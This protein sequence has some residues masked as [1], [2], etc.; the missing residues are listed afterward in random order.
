MKCLLGSIKAGNHLPE[1]MLKFYPQLENLYFVKRGFFTSFNPCNYEPT[2]FFYLD[3]T[4]EQIF[5]WL[6]VFDTMADGM[7]F[8]IEFREDWNLQATFID[9]TE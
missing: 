7:S 1:F 3:G 5:E 9:G 2:E 4:A 8:E 6:K